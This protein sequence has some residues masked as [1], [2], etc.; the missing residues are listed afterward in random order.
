MRV[1]LP[2]LLFAV[3]SFSVALVAQR[4]PPG[5]AVD[6]KAGG[7]RARTGAKGMAVA[8][9]D[10]GRV[11]DVRAYGVRNAKG[12]PLTTETVKYGASLTW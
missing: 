10:H 4:I 9:I 5:A 8:V 6:A 2:H 3:L 11:K 12:E 7:V 1:K